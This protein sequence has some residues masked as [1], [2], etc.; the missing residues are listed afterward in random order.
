MYSAV[1]LVHSWLRWAVLLAGVIAAVRGITGW[2]SGRPWN[3]SDDRVGQWFVRMLDV[4]VLLGLILYF[5]L[6]PFPRL[7]FQDVGAAMRDSALRFWTVEHTFG[8][9]VGIGIAHVGRARIRKS[10]NDARRH[11]LAAITFTLAV[12]AII[13]SIP[14]PGMPNGRPLFRW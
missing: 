1:L 6:S 5:V 9:L 12:L 13:A 10:P 3:L 7:A 11:R 14:W 4:Q 8:M 2:Q